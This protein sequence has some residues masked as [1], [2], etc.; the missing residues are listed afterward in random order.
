MLASLFGVSQ[1]TVSRIV[2]ETATTMSSILCVAMPDLP[3]RAH[4]A[5]LRASNYGRPAGSKGSMVTLV[6]DATEIS[7]RESPVIEQISLLKSFLKTGPIHWMNGSYQSQLSGC[8]ERND[9]PSPRSLTFIKK[10]REKGLLLD[11]SC[12]TH[13]GCLFRQESPFFA[14]DPIL[15]STTNVLRQSELHDTPPSP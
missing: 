11:L 14:S 7:Y 2:R 8:R 5:K 9:V 4:I 12:K 6:I 1:P 13:D 10:Y 15:A 3:Q